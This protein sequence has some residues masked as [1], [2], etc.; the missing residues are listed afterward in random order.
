MGHIRAVIVAIL[1][2]SVVCCY[3]QGRTELHDVSPRTSP[4][5]VSGV[6]SVVDDSSELVRSY[7]V[8]GHFHNVSNKGIVLI[9][10]S[11]A[12]K[13]TGHLLVLHTKRIISSATF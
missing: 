1:V 3:G 5:Q 9:V 11:S 4:V 10:G 13:T 2:G 6:V 7:Q 12:I 8:E